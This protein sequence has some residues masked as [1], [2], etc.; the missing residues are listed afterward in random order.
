ME[1]SDTERIGAADG[2]LRTPPYFTVELE[3]LRPPLENGC[4][5]EGVLRAPSAAPLVGLSSCR[6]PKHD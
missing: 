6:G 2:A 4:I 1:F 5:R 3:G